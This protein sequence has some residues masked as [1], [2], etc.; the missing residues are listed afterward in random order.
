MPFRFSRRRFFTQTPLPFFWPPI[1]SPADYQIRFRVF[2]AAA[3]I[4]FSSMFSPIAL[5]SMFSHYKPIFF[6][7]Y[8]SPA[9]SLI[10]RFRGASR[11]RQPP[12]AA[13]AAFASA[14]QAR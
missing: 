9:A 8:F 7:R 10:R 2:A 13:A 1:F 4:A 14:M 12:A 6:D 11:R 3:S 5:S